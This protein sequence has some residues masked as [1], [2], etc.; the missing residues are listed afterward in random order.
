M[1]PP[2]RE[3]L[4][5]LLA[6]DRP[7]KDIRH[8]LKNYPW[9][10]DYP[11]VILHREQASRIIN[12]YLHGK[13]SAS[14]VEGWANAIE[15]REDVGFESGFDEMLSELIFELANPTLTHTLDNAKAA[16]WLR[17]LNY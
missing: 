2:K 1:K 8:D 3:L 7:L 17:R 9:D 11:E 13:L 5:S 6:L 10:S 14:E 4:Q 12:R 16:E 15:G